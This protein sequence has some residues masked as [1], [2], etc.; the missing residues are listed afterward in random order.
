[1]NEEDMIMKNEYTQDMTHD[2]NSVNVLNAS[3]KQQH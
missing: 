2:S 3:N 1:M